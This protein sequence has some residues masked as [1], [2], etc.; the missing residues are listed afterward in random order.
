[1]AH[2]GW[3]ADGGYF[4]SSVRREVAMLEKYFAKPSTVDRLRSSWMGAAIEDYV[5][6]LAAH[7]Y[8]ERYVW[9]RVP[10]IFAFG[11]FAATRGVTRVEDLPAQV[12]AFV[13]YRVALHQEHTGSNRSMANEVRGPV[14]HMLSVVL[15]G[16]EQ[17]G[18]RRNLHPFAE[19]VPLLR[20]SCPGAGHS[21]SHGARL[22][23]PLGSFRN[24]SS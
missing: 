20:V 8:K 14:E 16:F 1:M 2:N 12:D 10:I 17:T 22:S 4:I 6:W 9:S 21:P 23:H 3:Q 11:E 15:A 18:R 5:V 24:L 19:T 13:E 7:D